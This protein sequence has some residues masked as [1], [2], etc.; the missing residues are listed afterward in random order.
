[1]ARN[2]SSA[3]STSPSVLRPELQIHTSHL[4]DT[5]KYKTIFDQ[6]V[7]DFTITTPCSDLTA[8]FAHNSRLRTFKRIFLLIHEKEKTPNV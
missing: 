7:I 5:L 1:M 8:C 4:C 6:G 3:T 2:L